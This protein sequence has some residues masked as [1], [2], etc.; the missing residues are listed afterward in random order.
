MLK[1]FKEF[2][3]KGNVVDLAVGVIL[4][5]KVGQKVRWNWAGGTH[6]V[7]AGDTGAGEVGHGAQ[8]QEVA[9]REELG[10]VV[11]T[12]FAT[13]RDQHLD[14]RLEINLGATAVDQQRFGRAANACAAEL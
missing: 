5:V 4:E 1:E 11:A 12:H 7:V 13:G 14:Q 10:G 3:M 9:G 6:N 2:A 8:R